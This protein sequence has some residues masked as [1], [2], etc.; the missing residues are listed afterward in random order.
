MSLVD[1]F[2][3]AWPWMGLGAAVVFAFLLFGTDL[4]RSGEGPRWRDPQWLAW[5]AVPMYLVHQFE[6]YGLHVTDGQFDIIAQVYANTAGVFDLSSL[7]MA[8]FPLVNIGLVWFGVPLAAWLCRRNPV[9]GLAPY[10]FILVN[11]LIHFASVFVM[12]TPVSENP[13][14]FTGTFLFLPATALVIYT[15]VRGD[16]MDGKGLAIALVAG[17]ISHMLLGAAYGASS[18]AGPVAVVCLDLFAS[19]GPVAL[20]WLGCK[21]FKPRV[22]QLELL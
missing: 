6:E 22:R 1:Q 20:G 9:I 18:A 19:F 4:L 12:G 15:C 8:H 17:I 2:W 14:F 11:G 10:G 5:A 21:L 7:P 16:F 13:G 3:Y